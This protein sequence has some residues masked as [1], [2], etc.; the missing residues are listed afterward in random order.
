ISE[1]VATCMEESSEPSSFRG[2][3]P[4]DAVCS[5]CLHAAVQSLDAAALARTLLGFHHGSL[6]KAQWKAALRHVDSQVVKSSEPRQLVCDAISHILGDGEGWREGMAGAE[7]RFKRSCG[8]LLGASQRSHRHT[9]EGRD[10]AVRLLQLA[11]RWR[12]P[13]A[14]VPKRV[15]LGTRDAGQ[16]LRQHH[17]ALHEVGEAMVR[18]WIAGLLAS[19]GG[20]QNH[21]ELAV[22]EYFTSKGELSTSDFRELLVD[23]VR[24]LLESSSSLPG[25]PPVHPETANGD[26]REP[27]TEGLTCGEQPASA[28]VEEAEHQA[29]GPALSPLQ[30]AVIIQHILIHHDRSIAVDVRQYCAGAIPLLRSLELRPQKTGDLATTLARLLDLPMA[31][32]S[33]QRPP[34]PSGSQAPSSGLRLP[35]AA[36]APEGG[37]ASGLPAPGGGD[38]EVVRQ[39]VDELREVAEQGRRPSRDPWGVLQVRL[40][41]QSPAPASMPASS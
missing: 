27:N 17:V 28:E 16:L 33:P 14:G 7:T 35:Q 15:T 29:G 34:P 9:P 32:S 41:R 19:D 25:V 21:G 5:W 3:Q 36:D 37:E 38:P 12:P 1:I 31:F 10:A 39:V 11:M 18:G 20:R 6:K 8:N 2:A 24:R 13:L 40:S 4:P 23:L 30:R 26:P 22:L